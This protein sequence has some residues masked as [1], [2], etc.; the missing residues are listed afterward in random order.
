[1]ILALTI[2]TILFSDIYDI[3][4]QS[5][6]H[7]L[8]YNTSISKPLKKKYQNENYLANKSMFALLFFLQYNITKTNITKKKR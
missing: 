6:L 8:L 7:K 2:K 4:A 5:P 3:N 1:M